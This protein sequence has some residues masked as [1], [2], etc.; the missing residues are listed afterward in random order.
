MAGCGGGFGFSN[1]LNFL[2]TSW[3]EFTGGSSWEAY[4]EFRNG[5]IQGAEPDRTCKI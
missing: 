5:I 3:W 1:E 2:L 4:Q